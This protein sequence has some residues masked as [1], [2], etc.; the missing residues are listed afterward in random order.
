MEL[1]I[2]QNVAAEPRWRFK[3][4]LPSKALTPDGGKLAASKL[5]HIPVNLL[6]DDR[7]VRIEM[8]ESRVRNSGSKTSGLKKL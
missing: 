1:P 4:S 6:C 7:L 3:S 8:E 2:F 5:R